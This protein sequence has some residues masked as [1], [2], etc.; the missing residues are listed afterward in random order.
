M[1]HKL[2]LAIASTKQ[3]LDTTQRIVVSSNDK[4][5][6]AYM[7]GRETALRQQLEVMKQLESLEN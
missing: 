6:R 1:N 2:S 7:L 5:M 3:A 4:I